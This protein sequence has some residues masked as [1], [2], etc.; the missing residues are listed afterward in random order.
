MLE[1]VGHLTCTAATDGSTEHVVLSASIGCSLCTACPGSQVGHCDVDS[2]LHQ[3]PGCQHLQEDGDSQAGHLTSRISASTAQTARRPPRRW[4]PA[5]CIHSHIAAFSSSC[6]SASVLRS[7]RRLARMS[8]TTWS[9]MMLGCS[10]AA[11]AGEKHATAQLQI[12]GRPGRACTY[13][14]SVARKEHAPT[15]RIAV[16]VDI[17]SAQTADP[18]EE[19]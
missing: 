3:I 17:R 15:Y 4:W 5:T 2:L 14:A 13:Q 1:A 11:T 19:A 9:S 7:F 8:A 6:T 18:V 12:P 10:A 16:V